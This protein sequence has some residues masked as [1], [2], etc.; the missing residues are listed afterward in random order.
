MRLE[1]GISVDH[2][3]V[4]ADAEI[5]DP[6]A[7]RKDS[8]VYRVALLIPMCGAA[9]LWG[10]SCIASAEVAL[11]ELNE[12]SGIGG[13]PVQV[14]VIDSALEA[15][16]PVESVIESLIE[17][18]QIDA[19][20]GMHISAVRQSLTKV[21]RGRIPFVYTPLYEGGEQSPGVFAIGDTPQRQLEPA[22]GHLHDHFRLKKWALVGNDYVWPRTSHIFAKRKIAQLRSDIVYERYLPFSSNRMEETVERISQSGA[23]GILLSLIG[24]DAVAF[25]RVFGAMNLHTKIVRLSCVIEENGL[26][27]SGA[28]NVDRLFSSASYF[29]ALNT[30]E[31]ASFREKYH[32]VHR[33]RAPMLNALG[34]STYEGMH[35]LARLING[36]G[37]DWRSVQ[38]NPS[39]PIQYNSARKAVYTSNSDSQA[40]VFLARATG[41]IFD[42]FRRIH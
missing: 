25:N 26:M 16:V 39:R 28:Q 8:D 34:Q 18:N 11:H 2:S 19:I 32:S 22:I 24:Q 23:D 14:S 1:S 3:F 15:P 35:F 36:S 20:V 17:N 13:R 29:A 31:N 4:Q 5:Q 38:Q 42:D 10:P 41:M 9:G 37:A 30:P 21:V 33:E 27:A 7:P 12:Q 6:E 40:P